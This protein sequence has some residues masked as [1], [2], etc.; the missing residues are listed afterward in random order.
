MS[1]TTKHRSHFVP[2]VSFHGLSQLW[3]LLEF[4]TR[5]QLRESSTA[6]QTGED[7]ESEPL[8]L[9]KTTGRKHF[10]GEGVHG[11]GQRSQPKDAP[12]PTKMS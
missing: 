9:L 2:G 5:D 4:S 12:N 11:R 1:P 6:I 10:G 7:T 8:I 3:S